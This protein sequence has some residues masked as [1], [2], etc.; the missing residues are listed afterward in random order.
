MNEKR[1][2]EVVVKEIRRR[3]RRKFTAE[4]KIRIILEGLRGEDSIS[5]IS[6]REGIHPNLYY[7]WSRDFLEAGKSRIKGDEASPILWTVFKQS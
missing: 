3:T 1:K 4:E 5:E 6:R 2:P 7:K